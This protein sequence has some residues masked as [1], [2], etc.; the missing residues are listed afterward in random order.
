[1]ASLPVA[2][3]GKL[4]VLTIDDDPEI[5]RLIEVRLQLER[6]TLV[7]ASNA[8]EGLRL[9][10]ELMPDLI[11][12]DV[13]LPD[14]SGFLV[15]RQIK[16]DPKTTP[17][18]VIFLTAAS[19]TVDKVKGL[20][21]GAVDYVLKP[22]DS[23]EL[24]ARVRAALRTKRYQDLLATQA[25]LDALTG[26][27]NRRYL[28]RR[29]DEELGAHARYGRKVA[30]IAVDID[31]LKQ[32]NDACGH[33]FGDILL[34]RAS[35]VMSTSLRVPDAVCRSGDDEFA[36]ILPETG[37]S[38]GM[39]VAERMQRQLSDLGLRHRGQPV[40]VTAS[41]GVA[42][43]EM[44]GTPVAVTRQILLST[45]ERALHRAKRDGCKCVRQGVNPGA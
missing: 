22:F 30:L 5:H 21:L 13:G 25:Q 11:L 34:Q 35:E 8:E 29:L 41:F 2:M 39:T 40:L 45:A 14:Q 38:G 27:W 36:L 10:R 17:I 20:D 18:P 37:T 15:C 44:F 4:T 9:A 33:P 24:R 32:I 28:E 1:M 23:A 7:R 6:L 3:I 42:S 12:L 26:R 16:G 43:T 31:H 19:D